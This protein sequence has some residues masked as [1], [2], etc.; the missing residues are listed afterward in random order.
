G[1]GKIIE[2]A[3]RDG[4]HGVIL[5]S[6][7]VKFSGEGVSFVEPPRGTDQHGRLLNES[8]DVARWVRGRLAEL[9]IN[10]TRSESLGYLLRGADPT[11]NE[12]LLAQTLANAALGLA[13]AGQFGKMVA[14]RF[15]RQSSELVL[16][17]PSLSQV[18]TRQKPVPQ[19]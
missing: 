5:I 8:G 14:T 1:V 2:E 16:A 6:E 15:A 12:I 13:R 4:S 3:W 7:G 11:A 19:G 9:H 10:N 17:Y 18:A